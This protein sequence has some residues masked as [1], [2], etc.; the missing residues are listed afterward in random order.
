MLEFPV[1]AE[2]DDHIL[3]VSKKD[4]LFYRIVGQKSENG[5]YRNK[6][7]VAAGFY[8]SV[9]KPSVSSSWERLPEL[10]DLWLL[11]SNGISLTPAS[12]VTGTSLTL[13]IP[14]PSFQDPF[15]YIVVVV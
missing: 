9:R 2:T 1:V 3:S 7:K 4:K 13:T 15:D 6:I 5:S 12:I 8:V 14:S 10:L 11:S